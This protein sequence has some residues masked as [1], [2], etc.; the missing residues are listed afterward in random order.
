MQR[1]LAAWGISLAI[2]F[3][4][5]VHVGPFALR[6]EEPAQPVQRARS[7]TDI[8]KLVAQPGP[9]EQPEEKKDFVPP[10]TLPT[11]RRRARRQAAAASFGRPYRRHR[12]EL[13][14]CAVAS[15]STR[16][17]GSSPAPFG[18]GRRR[19]L[20]AALGSVVRS[21]RARLPRRP[22]GDVRQRGLLDARPHRP[23]HRP[24]QDQPG[25]RPG[26]ERDQGALQRTLRPRLCLHRR[27]IASP[28]AS[29]SGEFE[30]HGSS[31]LAYRTNGEGWVARQ[32]LEGGNCDWGF[33]LGYSIL[34]GNDYTM[35]NGNTIPS[36]YNSQDV[37]FAIGF[38]LSQNQHIE[39]K[40]L[41]L[42]QYDMEY[43]GL[44]TDINRLST[45]GVSL[46]Y[47]ARRAP[48]STA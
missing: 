10:V 20:S 45:D 29:K 7:V 31:S 15:R 12:R 16:H 27:G 1:K 43:P 35:G 23:G 26:H 41:R 17:G 21:A 2:P 38:D 32:Y 47:V 33:R 25:L 18:W 13:D 9:A 14:D 6:G 42:Q 5:A 4:W 44:L 8:L 39:I 24:G 34:A 3:A 22:A 30:A 28:G 40:Y 46:R 11:R 19:R 36:S 37:D 48:G